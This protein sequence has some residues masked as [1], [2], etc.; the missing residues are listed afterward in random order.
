MKN[1][2]NIK[3]LD[4]LN[5]RDSLEV[6]Q[7]KSTLGSNNFILVNINLSLSIIEN[8]FSHFFF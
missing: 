7:R 6:F 2:E 5:Q 8:K 4:V 1:R 3:R